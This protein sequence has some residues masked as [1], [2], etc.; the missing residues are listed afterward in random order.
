MP[1][2]PPRS[3]RSSA[4][5][6]AAVC[7]VS[8]AAGVAALTPIAASAAVTPDAPVVIDE[9]YG[10]GGNSGAPLN[11]DFIELHNTSGDTVDLSGWSVQYASA[12]GA[13]WQVT[14]LTGV[15]VP[16]GES[17]LVGQA[18]GANTSLPTFE[19]D[20]EGTIAMSGS[21][22]K[23]VLVSS[24]TPIS[25]ATGIAN[26]A[27]IV[28]FV[29]WGN[30]GDWTGTGAAPA[31]SNTTSV[32]RTE[33]ANTANNAADFTAGAPTPTGL[34]DDGGPVDPGEPIAATIA[35]IQGTG[36]ASPLAGQTVRTE[37]FVTA[38]YPVGGFNGF[39]I[40]TQ[41]TGGALDLG[42]HLASDAL[43]VF[44]PQTVGQVSLGDFVA[45]TG[46]ISEWNGLTE[47]TVAPDG[48]EQ[49]S[50]S[51][52]AAP[53][54]ASVGWPTNDEQRESLESML[55][56]PTDTLIIADT[57]T[58]AQYGEV[59]LAAGDEGP[60][61]QPTDVA[62]PG[63]AEAAAVAARNAERKVVLDDG[64]STNFLSP[65]NQ[66][67]VPSYVSLTEPVVVGG[68]ATLERPVIVDWRNNAWKLNPT[69]P[70][71][72]DTTGADD[73]VAFS[74]PRTDGPADV[75]GAVTV[76]TFNVL[77]YFTTLGDANPACVAYN[78]RAGNPITVR[79]GCD[80]RGAW[81]A[82]NFERQETKIVE[83]ITGLDASVV[84]LLEIE[85]SARLGEATDEALAHLVDVLNARAG[86]D[87]WAYVA[88]PANLPDAASL[89]VITNAII[90]Q[91]AEVDLVGASVALA[92]QSGDDQAFGNAR[93]PI[94]QSFVP[95]SGGAPFTVIVNHFKSKS[96]PGPWPGDVDT[97]DGQGASVESR[98]RQADAL[99][100]WAATDPTGS[101]SDDVFL[102]GDFNSYGQETPMQHL[103]A[104][105]YA[106]AK[107]L[108]G[109]DWYSYVYQTLSG[110]LD[111]VLLSPGAAERFTGADAWELNAGESIALEYSRYN[112]YGALFWAPDAYRSSDHNAVIAGVSTGTVASA[113][114]LT[115]DRTEITVGETATA[116]VTVTADAP[117]NGTA[118]IRVDDAVVGTATITN[119]TGTFT[120]PSLS[121]GTHSVVAT[122]AGAG[123]VGASTSAPATL[124]VKAA[125]IASRTTL[126]PLLPVHINRILPTTLV[127]VVSSAGS[128]AGV[129]EFREGGTL[130]GTASV[131][132]GV[133][134]YTLPNTLSRGV[135]SYTATFVPSTEGVAGSTSGTAKVRVLR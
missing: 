47:L 134:T 57:Y 107:A 97:G 101:G 28:D 62:T 54:P 117:V 34:G 133:A 6:L 123:V 68:T 24:Q 89:D 22:G 82:A 113:T 39:V 58:T 7:A 127:A 111:H 15:S 12:A 33:H 83:A 65:A 25:G 50:P 106:D 76:A 8:L 37:G 35:E 96:S 23:V 124:T 64:S 72:G 19:A 109:A 70:I 126:V 18:F 71:V 95:A 86:E 67:L 44:A 100:A 131:R 26:L 48:I 16:A 92:D 122:F 114:T 120:L 81:D 103:Y 75:G 108:A 93:E 43:F 49:L 29:G 11:R 99:A 3:R 73:G 78:D 36:A 5:T 17:V 66:S 88:S 115:L 77:N 90:Y 132:R 13:T 87:R 74:N 84:G 45:V 21:A 9:V 129:V 42:S 30:A 32:S 98:T 59:V 85:N 94:A 91:P 104:A 79:E 20:V 121:I 61:V 53:I 110:S 119:G 135:H 55:V 46:E 63:S 56:Q 125:P 4:R 51:N 10:G 69:Q 130:I 128:T 27:S 105:G 41:G 116:T 40:Q 1:V 14:P 118:E 38:H 2:H 80:Q 112:N 60:L 102:V 31:T 52:V